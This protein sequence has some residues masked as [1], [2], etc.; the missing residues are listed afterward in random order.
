MT[1]DSGV[2][3]HT[4]AAYASCA[5]TSRGRL[6]AEPECS[7]RDP[8]QRDTDRITHSTAFRRL[9]YKTQVFVNHE[10]D[11]Y[12]TRLTHTLEVAQLTRGLCQALH[13]HAD[14]ASAVALAH[15]LGHPPFGHAGEE[16]L[17]QCMR[18]YGSFNHNVHALR[19]LTALEQRYAQFDGLNLTWETLEGV[20]KHNGPFAH[21]REVPAE[22]A[23]YSAQ[24]DLELQ[25]YPSAEAQ[26][27]ALADDIAY[28][29][30]DVD[31]GL[32]AGLFSL[33]ELCT[34]PVIDAVHT[35][36][37]Q[38]YRDLP[39]PRLRHEML[40]RLIHRM[41]KDA[42]QSARDM[43]SAC[44]IETAEDIRTLGR[45]FVHFSSQ[46]QQEND[47]LKQF[48]RT[49]MYHHY[50]VNRA[51]SKA[52]RI[53]KALFDFFLQEPECLPTDWRSLAEGVDM[54]ARAHVVA[55]FIA[56]MTDRFALEE[57]ERTV[58]LT[59]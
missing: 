8:Y 53:V 10:G 5:S 47:L 41:V 21:V 22:I 43:L 42:V 24:H 28:T 37:T 26:V 16:A 30:H 57:Y 4:L 13:L 12:R 2:P 11:H 50:Y 9:E 33:E 23:A 59:R 1:N 31:D 27:A 56:G 52:R 36:V 49:H 54:S 15:D 34:V 7:L 38:T 25:Y 14:L 44:R 20:A 46:M 18:P 48:L 58:A 19:L 51:T 6:H 40:R 32:R 39:A 55:D 3:S 45:S 35:E 29:S 17:Q